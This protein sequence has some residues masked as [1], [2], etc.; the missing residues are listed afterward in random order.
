MLTI[1]AVYLMI[2]HIAAFVNWQYD[3]GLWPESSRLFVG[4]MGSIMSVVAGLIFYHST[5]EHNG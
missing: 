3:A 1:I 4:G 5:K 2:F